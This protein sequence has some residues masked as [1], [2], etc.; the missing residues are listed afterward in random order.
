M[1]RP[2]VGWISFASI[3]M[4]LIGVLD[5]FEG[6]IAVIQQNY[7][8]VTSTQIVVWDVRTWGWITMIWGVALALIGLALLSGSEFA[9]WVGVVLVALNILEEL[10]WLGNTSYV[11]WTLVVIGLNIVVLYALTARWGGYTEDTQVEA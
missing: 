9:R 10:T 5:F 1:K 7:L 2:M 3:M 8:V 4:I 6:L 11:I